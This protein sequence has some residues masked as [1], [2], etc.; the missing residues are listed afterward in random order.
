MPRYFFHLTDGTQVMK[1]HKP[2][3]LDLAVNA[4]ARAEALMLARDLKHGR[5]MPER[6]WTGWFV[7]IVDGHGHQVDTVPIADAPEA[8]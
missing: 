8:S 2:E 5:L 1:G 4:A 7:R 6:K 3:G